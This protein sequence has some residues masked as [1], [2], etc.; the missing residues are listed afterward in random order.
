[1]PKIKPLKTLRK[2]PHSQLPTT[3]AAKQEQSKRSDQQQT[4]QHQ[5][6]G[7]GEKNKQ[8]VNFEKDIIG[9]KKAEFIR[10]ALMVN[11]LQERIKAP[12]TITASEQ[13]HGYGDNY[14]SSI[15]SLHED[16]VHSYILYDE[17]WV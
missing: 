10:K 17:T 16:Q 12:E 6:S 11:T 14:L 15:Y 1:M 7:K 9:Q 2:R 5:A 4:T 13:H 3:A 8:A